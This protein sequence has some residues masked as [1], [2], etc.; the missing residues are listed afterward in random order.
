[1]S[2]RYWQPLGQLLLYGPCP[3]LTPLW[4][5]QGCGGV[6][7]EWEIQALGTA[8]ARRKSFLNFFQGR[9]DPPRKPCSAAQPALEDFKLDFDNSQGK[10]TQNWHGGRATIFQ[11]LASEVWVIVWK[12]N[13]S[14]LRSLDK[15]GIKKEHIS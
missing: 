7:W 12:I 13:K 14:N 4:G 9:E 1:M 6:W 8:Q 15:Q 3:L 11:S 10:T 5:P 2:H